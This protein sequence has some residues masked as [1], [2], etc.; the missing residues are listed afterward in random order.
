MKFFE[1]S[2]TH[3]EPN[4][5]ESYTDCGIVMAETFGKAADRVAREF[6]TSDGL[7]SIENLTISPLAPEDSDDLLI[8]SEP[9]LKA[10]KEDIFW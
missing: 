3:Y 10:V 4:E 8:L 1:F 6:A 2:I 5:S 7:A 9:V